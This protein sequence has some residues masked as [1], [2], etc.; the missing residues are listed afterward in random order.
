[1]IT[2]L[3]LS[4]LRTSRNGGIKFF[5]PLIWMKQL[6]TVQIIFVIAIKV[7]VYLVS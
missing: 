5:Y 3:Q 2:P 4:D 7:V 6:Q 1:M